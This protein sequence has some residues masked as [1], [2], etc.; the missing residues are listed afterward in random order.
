MKTVQKDCHPHAGRPMA[1]ASRRSAHA[2]GFPNARLE[3]GHGRSEVTSA[4]RRGRL[5]AALRGPAKAGPYVAA[6]P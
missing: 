4:V 5:Q 2:V 6:P 3:F 1:A